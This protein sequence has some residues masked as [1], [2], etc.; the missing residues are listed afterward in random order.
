MAV[1]GSI[2]NKFTI[3]KASNGFVVTDEQGTKYVFV[4]IKQLLKFI[5]KEMKKEET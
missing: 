3:E 4:N 1:W 2:S 5:E